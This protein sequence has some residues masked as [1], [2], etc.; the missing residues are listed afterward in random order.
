MIRKLFK[1]AFAALSIAMLAVVFQPSQSVAM[2][3][4]E[5]VIGTAETKHPL[6]AAGNGMSMASVVARTGVKV[7]NFGTK[8]DKDNLKRIAKS[9]RAI[10]LALVSAKALK[11]AAAKEKKAISGLI[12]VGKHN[13][14]TI[15]LVARN[16]APKGL[17]KEA[18]TKALSAVVAAFKSAKGKKFVSKEW[19]DFAPASADAEFKAAGVSVHKAAMM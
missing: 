17:S 3:E 14:D 7:Y 12:A 9:K 11:A 6:F 15:L 13:G 1:A 19:K 4:V 16:A 5:L 18:Y 2:D 10:N 8:G